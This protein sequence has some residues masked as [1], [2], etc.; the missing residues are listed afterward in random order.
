MS[1]TDAL[2][3]IEEA[4]MPIYPLGDYKVAEAVLPLTKR[5]APKRVSEQSTVAGEQ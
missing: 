2:T 3:W 5:Q 4:M 1:P